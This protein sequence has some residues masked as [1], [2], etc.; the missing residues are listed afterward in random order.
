MMQALAPLGPDGSGSW[1]GTSGRCGVAV[2]ASLRRSTSEESADRQ[3]ARSQDGALLLVG[4]LRVDNRGDLAPML[5]LTDGAST[6]DSSFVL[7]GYERWGEAILDRVIGE[8]A[9]AIVDRRRGGVLLAR[10]HV[11]ARPLVTHHRRGIV[12]FASMPLALTAF[13]G[14]GHQL[15]VHHAAEVLALAYRSERTF[16][17]DVRWLPAGNALWVDESGVRRWAWWTPDP[18]A[19]VDLGSPAAHER[20]LRETFE[21]AVAA[22]L[23]SC[24]PVGATVSGGLDSTSAAATAAR[25]VAPKVLPTFTAAPAPGWHAPESPQWDADESPLVHALAEMHPNI[26]PTFIHIPPDASVLSVQEPLW[27]L[28]A[29]PALNPCNMLWV[30]AIRARAGAAGM[31]TLLSGDFGNL[32]FSADGPQWLMSHLRAGRAVTAFREASAW[33]SSSGEGGCRTVRRHVLPHVL[34]VGVVRLARRIAARPGPRETWMQATALRPEV[35]A[36]LDLRMLPQ[37]RDDHRR[38]ARVVNLSMVAHYAG[39]ADVQSALT[40]VTG[41]ETRDP[42]SDRRVLET[43]MRQPEWVRRHDGVTRAV[44]RGAMR[45]R[46][47]PAIV[48]R[49][50]RG[51][52]LP[53]WLDVLT[54]ARP[55]LLSELDELA[56]HPA[57]RELID[58]AR[59]RS[60]VARWPEP[61]ERNDPQVVRD[62]RLALPRALVV[63]R[64]LRWFERRAAAGGPAAAA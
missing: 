39:S 4:D 9:I 1:A 11:G 40:G 54:G 60:M 19:V 21:C 30:F 33:R 6:P 53:E 25:L 7:S 10:D 38:D 41:V 17:E 14:V 59:L 57:S 51:E 58:V 52:Q 56:M 64:Y 47:P 8:F 50:L 42:T 31:T 63:S 13:E 15:D 35:A 29:G 34:P 45:D 46:L 20:E 37:L 48:H 49:T 43:A 24:G 32:F 5:G 26:E 62:Y 28:G 2:G 61:G 27:E 44:A 12:A 36:M 22:R 18:H 16:V 55:A 23:R 3:P